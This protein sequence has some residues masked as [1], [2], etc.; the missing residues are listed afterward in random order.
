MDEQ[1]PADSG[2]PGRQRKQA[3]DLA[4]TALAAGKPVR[5]AAAEAGI[6]ERTLYSW[7]RKES[8]K[9]RVAQ[10]R[11]RLVSAAIGR[12]SK[13][14]GSAAVVLARLMKSPDEQ[15]RL[16][17]SKAILDIGGKLTQVEELQRRVEALELAQAKGG[18]QP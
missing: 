10:L 18:Q 6:G 15:V 1:T 12:L 8:F 4:A 16:R 7:M 11:A 5:L 9:R 17:A 13:S 2:S 3:A 14:M